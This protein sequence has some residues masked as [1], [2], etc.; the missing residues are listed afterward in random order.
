MDK[1]MMIAM[2][3]FVVVGIT[4]EQVF[5]RISET[6]TDT[7]TMTANQFLSANRDGEAVPSK[8]QIHPRERVRRRPETSGECSAER[9]I[10][11]THDP[12]NG[13]VIRVIDGDTFKINVDGIEMAVRLWGIDA[14]E[15]DQP[16]GQEAR[17]YLGGLIPP[18]SQIKVHPLNMDRYGRMVGSVDNGGK[19]AVNVLMVAYGWAYDYKE[20]SAGGNGCLGEAERAARGSRMGMWGN[21]MDRETRPWEH[22]MIGREG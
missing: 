20:Y 14:P 13:R 2:A 7:E 15:A 18:D 17:K 12:I 22:R 16:G 5:S 9:L 3:A 8:P 21:Q 10:P 4:V 19:W 1:F 11:S 6:E